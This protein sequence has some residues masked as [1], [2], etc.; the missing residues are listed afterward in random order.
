MAE[1][2]ASFISG[3]LAALEVAEG[4]EAAPEPLDAEAAA[5]VRAELQA[6]LLAHA[7]GASSSPAWMP[8]CQ[9]D[10][11]MVMYTYTIE[12]K[13]ISVIYVSIHYMY[14]YN[15]LDTYVYMFIYTYIE[16]L[17]ITHTPLPETVSGVA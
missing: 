10:A 14:I 16:P 15:A 9:P 6:G 3:R 2:G 7:Q 8:L 17:S 12:H 11:D 13:Q 5:A 4:E 1:P